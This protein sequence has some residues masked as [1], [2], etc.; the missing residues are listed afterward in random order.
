MTNITKYGG[1]LLLLMA[2]V[3]AATS[4]ASAPPPTSLLV[5]TPTTAPLSTSPQGT[6][7]SSSADSPTSIAGP[8]ELPSKGSPDAKVTLVMFTGFH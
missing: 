3:W 4:C 2:V 7:V 1:I 6:E 5:S 8:E